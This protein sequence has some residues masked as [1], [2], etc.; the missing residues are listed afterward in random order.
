MAVLAR[1]QALVA[2]AGE[3]EAMRRARAYEAAGADAIVIHSRQS[4][5]AE[6]ISFIDHWESPTPLVLIPTTYSRFTASQAAATGKVRMM[7]YAN[8]GLR[9]SL[10]A[11][12][13]VFREILQEDGTLHSERW[14]AP[15]DD[16][17]K[18]QADPRTK[19]G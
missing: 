4:D 13:R 6:I 7:I 8:H 14:I 2:G 11:M 16:V 10:A 15:L 9:A 1:V 17:F 3:D 19:D 12:Q 18:L 5:P